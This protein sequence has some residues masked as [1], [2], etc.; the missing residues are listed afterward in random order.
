MA[1]ASFNMF[2]LFIERQ[3][4]VSDDGYGDEDAIIMAENGEE[5][6]EGIQRNTKQD[7]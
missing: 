1:N 4:C 5:E 2:H 7:I 3:K 6:E